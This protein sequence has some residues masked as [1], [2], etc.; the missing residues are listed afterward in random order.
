MGGP[1]HLPSATNYNENLKERE[2]VKWEV[3]EGRGERVLTGAG[4]G[5]LK[6]AAAR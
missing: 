1:R 6:V 2:L 4:I 5:E 3:L